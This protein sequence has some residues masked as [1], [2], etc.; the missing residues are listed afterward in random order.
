[1]LKCIPEISRPHYV[2]RIHRL[3]ISTELRSGAT[4]NGMNTCCK[5]GTRIIK[6]YR[7]TKAHKA[8]VAFVIWVWIWD[9][10]VYGLMFIRL[11]YT[12]EG[13]GQYSIIFERPRPYPS[14]VLLFS[15]IAFLSHHLSL[16]SL[17]SRISLLFSQTKYSVS[18]D[19]RAGYDRSNQDLGI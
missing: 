19:C 8:T 17:F 14:A 2:T 18:R 4:R 15:R 9:R 10:E 6:V 12:C 11:R 1:M 13:M 3:M 5:F 7:L 16:A